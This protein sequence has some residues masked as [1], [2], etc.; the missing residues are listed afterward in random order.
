MEPSP[1]RGLRPLRLQVR[2]ATA[3]PLDSAR[4][5]VRTLCGVTPRSEA[6]LAAGRPSWINW[7]AASLLATGEHL[8]GW[9]VKCFIG[10]GASAI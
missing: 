4:T 2:S 7:T 1:I 9:G 5:H 8:S 3:P 6:T 10:R